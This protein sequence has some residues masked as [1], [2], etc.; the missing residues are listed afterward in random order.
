MNSGHINATYIV[1]YARDGGEVRR[2]ILQRINENVF[3]DPLVV[4]RNVECVTDHINGKVLHGENDLGYPTEVR[5]CKHPGGLTVSW[6]L[7]IAMFTQS[8]AF[9]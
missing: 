3:K 2:Y 5:F 8:D 9:V 4:M 1:S 6:H 7:D